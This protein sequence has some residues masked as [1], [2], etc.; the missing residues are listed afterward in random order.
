M[1]KIWQPE[2]PITGTLKAGTWQLILTALEAGPY[3]QVA[4]AIA[5]VQAQM[6]LAEVAEAGAPK[7]AHRRTRPLENGTGIADPLDD[8]PPVN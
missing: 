6:A 3:K 2:E 5:E 1:T 8:P 7:R 4:P